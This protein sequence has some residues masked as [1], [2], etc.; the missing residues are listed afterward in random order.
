MIYWTINQHWSGNNQ[1]VIIYQ[2]C[3]ISLIHIYTTWPQWFK[4]HLADIFKW[5]FI[6]EKNVFLS[7]I[8]QKYI[9]SGPVDITSYMNIFG[10]GNGFVADWWQAITWTTDD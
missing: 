4:C 5:I 1:H 7:A 3:L 8:S 6:T 2:W 10:S 9:P